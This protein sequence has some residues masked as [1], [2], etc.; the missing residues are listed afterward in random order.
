M[1]DFIRIEGDVLIIGGGAA[2]CMAA[3]R[4]KELEPGLRVVILEQAALERSGRLATGLAILSPYLHRDE[5]VESYIAYLASLGRGPVDEAVVRPIVERCAEV[6]SRLTKLGLSIEKGDDAEYARAGRW[7]VPC[8]GESL[9]PTLARRA[10]EADAHILHHVTATGLLL[11]GGR[12]A[13]AT[14]FHVRSGV[15][16][17]ISAPAVLLATGSTTGLYRSALAESAPHR[18]IPAPFNAGAGLALGLRAGLELVGLEH[19][20]QSAVLAGSL[21]PVDILIEEYRLPALNAQGEPIPSTGEDELTGAVI[22]TEAEGKGSCYIE[23]TDLSSDEVE[24]ITVRYL[25]SH[26][27]AVLHW[28]T[29]GVSPNREPLRLVLSEPFVGGLDSPAGLAVDPER[30]TTLTGLYAAGETAGGVP[31][32]GITGVF[33]EALIAAEGI[34]GDLEYLERAEIDEQEAQREN[35]RINEPLLRLSRIG[36]GV[37][38]H[39]FEQRLQRMM[40]TYAGGRAGSYRLERNLLIKARCEL[41][42]LAAQISYLIGS[43]NHD[44][45][46][47]LRAQNRLLVARALVEHLIGRLGGKKRSELLLSALNSKTGRPEL[48]P[49]TPAKR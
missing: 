16:H 26:P 47:C 40:D 17:L 18:M 36:E 6:I 23:T 12:V 44:A 8:H 20:S 13:G 48:A 49:T 1:A 2:G 11:D 33:A 4:L 29:E 34:A 37:G 42:N 9:K 31:K 21:A 41:Q 19:R 14:G 27:A 39:E 30:R 7:G 35:R 25:E 46:L 5:S 3:I 10:V 15:F 43:S 24:R 28:R 38:P 22:T 32:K 45:V